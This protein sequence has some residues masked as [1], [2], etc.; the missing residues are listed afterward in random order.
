MTTRLLP[1]VLSVAV[2]GIAAAGASAVTF[3]V[4]VTNLG[5]QPLAPVFYAT[6][7][8]S[9][10]IFTNGAAASSAIEMEAE[11]G[12]P[13]GLLGL[14]SAAGSNVMS[15]GAT[16]GPFLTGQFRT[17]TIDA[18][19]SHRWFQFASMLGMTN[20]AFIG[21]AIGVGDN[22]IDL[23]QGGQP[24]TA[25]FTQSFLNVWDA[26]TEVNSELLAHVPPNMG[27]GTTEG[28]V[29]MQPHEGITG[30]GDI[31]TSFDWY[32]G[33]VARITI[34]PVPE[35]ATLSALALGVVALLR[36]RK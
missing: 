5:P 6:S 33:D 19:L 24:I 3:T 28:G 9:F 2:A 11:E 22:Q 29:V 14:A 13:T 27:A 18:D 32:G 16:T 34:A 20:D 23:F 17:F 31:S 7:N 26:G 10:D 21:S 25:T 36:R 30:R 35:P 1:R 15:F 12:S 4:T 8:T